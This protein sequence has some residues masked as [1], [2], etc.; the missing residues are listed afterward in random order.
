MLEDT[1]RHDITPKQD[2]W[3]LMLPVLD[4]AINNSYQEGSKVTPFFAN[5]GKHP[6]LPRNIRLEKKPNKKPQAYD[7]IKNIEK[8]R[9]KAKIC[10]NDAQHCQKN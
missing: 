2:N 3:D 8:T 9:Q 7:F 5:Y 10:L 4:F 6:C 1:S